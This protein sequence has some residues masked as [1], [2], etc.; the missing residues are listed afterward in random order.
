MLFINNEN[1][2]IRR[3]TEIKNITRRDM[4]CDKIIIIR[5]SYNIGM[6]LLELFFLH[7]F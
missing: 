6:L 4:R 5:K 1:S 3:R 2:N 7:F